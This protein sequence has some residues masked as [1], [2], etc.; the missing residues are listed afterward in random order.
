[1]KGLLFI[2][3]MARK[4]CD[5]TKTQTRRVLGLYRDQKL[6]PFEEIYDTCDYVKGE[7]RALLTTWAVAPEFDRL[8]PTQL[9]PNRVSGH[10]WHAGM[11]EKPAG[12]GK[13]RPGRFLPN[14]LR[15]LMMPMFD[16]EDVRVE[17]VKEIEWQDAIDEG[18]KIDRCGCDVCSTT[19]GFCTSDQ[20]V[21]VMEFRLLWDSINAKRGFGWDKNPVVAVVTFKRL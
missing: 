8:K 4:A 13:S 11:G 9:D 1:M 18:I 12:F 5:G 15:G 7:R 16:I 3:E 19:A 17:R 10:F 6:I 2:P 14:V 20:G 21:A